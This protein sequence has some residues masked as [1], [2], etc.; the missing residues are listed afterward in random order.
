[1]RQTC[2]QEHHVLRSLHPLYL[3]TAGGKGAPGHERRKAARFER[4]VD[5]HMKNHM[6]RNGVD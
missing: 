1:M 3:R 2:A 5:A 4:Y 6:F